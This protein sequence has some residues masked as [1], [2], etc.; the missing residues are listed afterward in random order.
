[1]TKKI[2][3]E[4]KTALWI[5]KKHPFFSLVFQCSGES[6]QMDRKRAG[7]IVALYAQNIHACVSSRF[8]SIENPASLCRFSSQGKEY[9]IKVR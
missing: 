3:S 4:V 2:F 6:C 9:I 1:M 8:Q 5:H 7:A